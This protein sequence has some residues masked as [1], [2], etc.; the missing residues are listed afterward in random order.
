M[1]ER[2]IEER[3]SLVGTEIEKTVGTE[4]TAEIAVR[5]GIGV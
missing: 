3:M 2:E 1:R 5:V 4:A